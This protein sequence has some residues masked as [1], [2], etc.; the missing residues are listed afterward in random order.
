MIDLDAPVWRGI[1]QYVQKSLQQLEAGE[2]G[3]RENVDLLADNT[4]HQLSWYDATA[5]ALPH[6]ARL[7]KKL[8]VEEKLYLIAQMGPA[9]AAESQV[10]LSPDSHRVPP[11]PALGDDKF[12]SGQY[13]RSGRKAKERAAAPF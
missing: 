7:C 4:S 10:S 8:S 12:H 11:L 9:V 6:V 5:Y 1:N 3:F 2:G 13:P